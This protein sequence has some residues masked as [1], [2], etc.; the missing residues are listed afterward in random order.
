VL[1]YRD[2]AQKQFTVCAPMIRTC[3]TS[4]LISVWPSCMEFRSKSRKQWLY[5]HR[6]NCFDPELY[7]VD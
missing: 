5:T 1:C 7:Q 4:F 2:T 6:G 3:S